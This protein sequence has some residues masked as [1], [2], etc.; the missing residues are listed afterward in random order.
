MGEASSNHDAF[1]WWPRAIYLHAPRGVWTSR[2]IGVSFDSYRSQ[3]SGAKAERFCSTYRLAKSGTFSIAKFGEEVCLKLCRLWVHRMTYF[4]N[5]WRD[6]GESLDYV[7]GED[8][9]RGYTPPNE[10]RE[11][12]EEGTA[13]VQQRVRGFSDIA[14][15]RP[16]A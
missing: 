14:P 10:C 15:K 16:P 3:A 1:R 11:L 5:I 6:R 9:L 4:F 7:F 13:V 12:L 8:E 2:H